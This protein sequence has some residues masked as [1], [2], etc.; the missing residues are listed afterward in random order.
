MNSCMNARLH[1]LTHLLFHPAWEC[2]EDGSEGDMRK[3]GRGS[4][5][6]MSAV[7]RNVCLTLV[8]TGKMV[9]WS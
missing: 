5:G 1:T 8:L 9:N 6:L 7:W 3:V 4:N 2:G